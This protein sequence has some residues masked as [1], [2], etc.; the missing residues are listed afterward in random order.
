MLGLEGFEFRTG[1]NV[2]QLVQMFLN[3]LCQQLMTTTN[4]KSLKEKA[5]IDTEVD[6]VAWEAR[7]KD[8]DSFDVGSAATCLRVAGGLLEGR[9]IDGG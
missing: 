4:D 9:P 1:L 5:C 6:S 3:S 7:S 8:H 2:R